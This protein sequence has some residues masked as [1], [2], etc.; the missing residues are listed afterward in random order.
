MFGR[1]NYTDYTHLST[2]PPKDLADCSA[3]AG[4]VPGRVIQWTCSFTW[5]VDLL[6]LEMLPRALIQHLPTPKI[7]GSQSMLVRQRVARKQLSICNTGPATATMCNT[8]PR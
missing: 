2:D 7:R 3:F 4:Y 8:V 6:M 1:S 5:M